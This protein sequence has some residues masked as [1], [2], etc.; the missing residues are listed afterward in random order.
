[1]AR[2]FSLVILSLMIIT[3]GCAGRSQDVPTVGPGEDIS[4][5]YLLQAR[6]YRDSGRYDLA[7][8]SYALA[9]S[10]CRNNANLAII[11]HELAGT[12]LLIRTMR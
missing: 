4:V 8:Q 2:I 9:M 11:K 12:Q 1:M 10:T 3:A 6:Q 7:R 5:R